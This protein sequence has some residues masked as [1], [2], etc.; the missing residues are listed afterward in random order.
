MHCTVVLLSRPISKTGE[1]HPWMPAWASWC[2]AVPCSLAPAI[3]AL[4]QWQ[5]TR[6]EPLQRPQLQCCRRTYEALNEHEWA[7]N[8]WRF[9]LCAFCFWQTGG[10][11]WKAL[12]VSFASEAWRSFDSGPEWPDLKERYSGGFA[13]TTARTGVLAVSSRVPINKTTCSM[14]ALCRAHVESMLALCWA[15][16]GPCWAMLGPRC[17]FCAHVGPCCAQVW[18]LAN[19][20][21]F[22]KTW[23]SP[24]F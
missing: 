13:T 3:F 10:I 22:S 17:L 23:N 14:L 2:F 24:R 18:R 7:W 6:H 11:S 9:S 16:S 15:A 20:T 1:V 19:F 21:T 12:L 4:I 5:F 8:V